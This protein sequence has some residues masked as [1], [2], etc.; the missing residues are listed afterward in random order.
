MAWMGSHRVRFRG[1]AGNRLSRAMM[2]RASY[3]LE[4]S[5]DGAEPRFVKRWPIWRPLLALVLV[6]LLIRWFDL[7]LRIA[8][9][10]FDPSSGGFPHYDIPPWNW[11]YRLGVY[12]AFVI[13]VGGAVIAAGTWLLGRWPLTQRSGLFLAFLLALGP[14]LVVNAGLKNFW[15][16]PRPYEVREFGGPRRFLQVGEIGAVASSNSSFPSGHAAVAFYLLAPA[17]LVPPRRRGLMI[18]LF[19]I[20]VGYGLCMGLTRVVQGGHFV[21]DVL[22]SGGMVY[23]TAAG[24]SRKLLVELPRQLPDPPEAFDYW[25]DHSNDEKRL[26]TREVTPLSSATM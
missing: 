3:C 2:G 13:G 15:G 11:I 4:K 14:G 8:S 17:F 23:L 10:F 1:R 16:R 19:A 21:S 22:W 12:P 25:S 24:L 6:S 18:A 9:L 7:D 26:E 5:V 20:G